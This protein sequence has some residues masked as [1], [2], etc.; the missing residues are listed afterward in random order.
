MIE[1]G[2]AAIPHRFR[3]GYFHARYHAP[4]VGVR[5]VRDQYMAPAIYSSREAAEN[6]ARD[7]YFLAVNGKRRDPVSGKARVVNRKAKAAGGKLAALV[8]RPS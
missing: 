3:P 5:W 4:T 6:A 1:H 7:A 8:F 2:Y